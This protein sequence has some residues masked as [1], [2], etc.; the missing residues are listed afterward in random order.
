MLQH[1]FSIQ[2]KGRTDCTIDRYYDI[3]S[4]KNGLPCITK[5]D[6]EFI[7]LIFEEYQNTLK[8][9]G[10]FDVDDVIMEALAPLNAPVWRRE[11]VQKGYDYIIVD[12]MH[13]FNVNEQSVFHFLTK[14]A[15][16]EIPICFALDYSQAI[17]ERGNVS[18][19]YIET[20]FG[21]HVERKKYCTV[22]RNSPQI[23]EF[24]ASLAAAG[25]LMFQES[26]MN[27]YAATKSNFTEA[28]E[29]KSSLPA[30][31]MYNT[32]TDMYNSL[33]EHIQVII[34]ELQCKLHEIAIISF[35]NMLL[36]KEGVDKL[37]KIIKK[38]IELI[39][40]ASS[41]KSNKIILASPYDINGLEFQ[42]VVLIGADEGRVPQTTGI[43]DISKHFILYSAYN[44]L[45]IASSRAKYKLVILGNRLKGVSSCLEYSINTGLI[46][47]KNI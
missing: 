18:T 43:S 1:E 44:L 13:L 42:A 16:K 17:G 47:N 27:P 9:E 38:D 36:S 11:R 25:T 45:Y 31:Y 15:G 20:E 8:E 10:T 7:F 34:K 3:A 39:D 24:C 28:E 5:R 35:D 46:D 6:K 41:A 21:A 33:E 23:S 26:F 12:E 14:H 32:D 30:L 2:I 40:F 22:F 37:K 19:D 29:K 4:I